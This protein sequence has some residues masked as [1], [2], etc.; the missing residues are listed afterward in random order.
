MTTERYRK[1]PPC[2][3]GRKQHSYGAKY[4]GPHRTCSVVQRC[5]H[6][7]V[8]RQ[9]LYTGNTGPFPEMRYLAADVQSA[10]ATFAADMLSVGCVRRVKSR[11]RKL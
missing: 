6:C 2:I 4:Y 3:E 8:F 5:A 7:G 1:A 10:K 11:K 9:V